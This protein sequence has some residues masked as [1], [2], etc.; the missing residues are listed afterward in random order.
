MSVRLI[1]DADEAALELAIAKAVDGGSH[2]A[3]QLLSCLFTLGNAHEAD[4]LADYG[5]TVVSVGDV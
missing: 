5:I 2:C 3:A 1:V 4:V